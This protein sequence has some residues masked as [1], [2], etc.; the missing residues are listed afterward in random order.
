MFSHPTIKYDL[1]L[2]VGKTTVV[3]WLVIDTQFIHRNNWNRPESR[4]PWV[5]SCRLESSR[6]SLRSEQIYSLRSWGLSLIFVR[7]RKLWVLKSVTVKVTK[8][9]VFFRIQLGLKISA[10]LLVK[11]TPLFNGP[12]CR[13]CSPMSL[14]L[15]TWVK[16]SL[17]DDVEMKRTTK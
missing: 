14:L 4:H 13:F 1:R 17:L 6:S 8:T 12:I 5:G 9:T 15:S 2:R 10:P 16:K 7:S 3:P 11:K